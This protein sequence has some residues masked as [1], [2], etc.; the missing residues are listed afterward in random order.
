M[1]FFLQKKQSSFGK[2]KVRKT[3]E[4]WTRLP[5]PDDD[6]PEQQR[7]GLRRVGKK[8]EFWMFTNKL[9]DAF[10]LQIGLERTCEVRLECCD[11]YHLTPAHTRRRQDIRT[12]DWGY[13]VRVVAACAE[14]HLEVDDDGRTDAEAILEPIYQARMKRLGISEEKALIMLKEIALRIQEE[15]AP[16]YNHF[17]FDYEPK[18]VGRG[19]SKADERKEEREGRRRSREEET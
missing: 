3:S 12:G 16:K 14:C 5:Q 7:K 4:K 6:K 1:A 11:N 18:N 8:G 19:I 9:I 17:H 15:F 2:R 13:A 10:I